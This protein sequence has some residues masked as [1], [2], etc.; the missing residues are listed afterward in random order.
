MSNQPN[1]PRPD[2]PQAAVDRVFRR[3]NAVYGVQRMAAAWAGVPEDERA[4]VW[5]R[6]IGRAVWNGTT[7][8]LQAVADA[9]DELGA[10]AS[11]WPPS[12]GE[13]AERCAR[14]AQRPG[15][16]LALPV[17]A[18]SEAEIARG[19]EHMDRI[20]GMLGRA[21]DRMVAS[22]ARAAREPGADYEPLV[23]TPPTSPGCTCGVGLTRAP[24]LCP[25]CR[26]YA[27][28]REAVSAARNRRSFAADRTLA[29]EAGRKGGLA[30]HKPRG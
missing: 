21:A 10:E 11:P 28:T 15:R 6:A 24:C 26:G 18:R 4:A 20:R 16:V 7:F 25:V 2:L 9:L 12:S 30:R 23:S 5:G 13:F 19:R 29:A 14:L 8:D 27:A 17:P 1:P 3:L 22:D